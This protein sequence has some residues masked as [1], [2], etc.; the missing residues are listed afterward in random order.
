MITSRPPPGSSVNASAPGFANAIHQPRLSSKGGRA[1]LTVMRARLVK[2]FLSWKLIRSKLFVSRLAV[3]LGTGWTLRWPILL[4]FG[5]SRQSGIESPTVKL[6]TLL[7]SPAAE[8]TMSMHSCP[9]CEGT[10]SNGPTRIS[11]AELDG[12]FAAASC[13]VV[14]ACQDR[15]SVV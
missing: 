12:T 14:I 13:G 4:S 15:K 3:L 1:A 11:V 7:G 6:S 5:T 8:A 2:G 9:T 10:H